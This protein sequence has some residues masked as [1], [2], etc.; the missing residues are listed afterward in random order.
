LKLGLPYEW[1]TAQHNDKSGAGS[2]GVGIVVRF[3]TEQAT[4]IGVDIKIQ[5]KFIF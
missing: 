1:E 5:V 3:V 2:G 4:E